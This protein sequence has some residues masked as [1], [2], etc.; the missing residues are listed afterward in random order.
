MTWLIRTTTLA[1][2]LWLAGCNGGSTAPNPAPAETLINGTVTIDGAPL[3]DLDDP[4]A[5]GSQDEDKWAVWLIDPTEDVDSVALVNGEDTFTSPD[6]TDAGDYLL[7]VKILPAVDLAGGAEPATPVEL[8]IPVSLVDGT[9]T[10][11]VVDV[12]FLTP[13]AVSAVRTSSQADT[14]A[15]RVR[16]H[17]SITG[18]DGANELIELNWGSRLLR[19]DTNRDGLVSDEADYA[20]SDRDCISDS[21]FQYLQQKRHGQPYTLGGMITALKLDE[22]RIRVG[23]TPVLVSEATRIHRGMTELRLEQLELGDEVSVSGQ[24]APD[25]RIFAATISVTHATRRQPPR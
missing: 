15:Y 7:A 18:A 22:G 20:D 24:R 10:A 8:S 16:L 23:E 19:R 25:G 13:L 4:A 6:V 3:A 14:P 2:L 21:L 11:A 1:G 9:T 5:T 12:N 17:Y